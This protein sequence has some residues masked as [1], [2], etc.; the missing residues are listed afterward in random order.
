VSAGAVKALIADASEPFLVPDVTP[1]GASKAAVFHVLRDMVDAGA[2]EHHV[3]GYRRPNAAA[4]AGAGQVPADTIERALRLASNRLPAAGPV[5]DATESSS[6]MT[7][8]EELPRSRRSRCRADTGRADVSRK[9]YADACARPR[10]R[11]LRSSGALDRVAVVGLVAKY[12][13]PHDINRLR[14]ATAALDAQEPKP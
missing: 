11:P 13:F 14:A 9:T 5:L 4:S 10:R 2:L 1:R 3:D 12:D 8:I 6:S 7:T